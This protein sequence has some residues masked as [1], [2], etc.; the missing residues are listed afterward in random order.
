MPFTMEVNDMPLYVRYGAEPAAY[1]R[2][3]E[4][5]AG[6]WQAIGNRPGVLD[7]TVHAHVFGRPYGL[8]EFQ[9][10]IE[11]AR[12]HSWAWL[13]DHHRLAALCAAATSAEA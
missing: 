8:V 12:R 10:A 5:I 1:S 13:A 9:A 6:Q 2:I 11:A 3:F 7:L 4:R